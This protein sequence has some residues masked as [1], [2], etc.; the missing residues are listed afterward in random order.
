MF[1]LL[2]VRPHVKPAKSID[3]KFILH[4]KGAIAMITRFQTAA[5][6]ILSHQQKK[7]LL[8]FSI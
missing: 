2:Y 1:S 3:F 6:P 7:G 4:A 8:V 5:G